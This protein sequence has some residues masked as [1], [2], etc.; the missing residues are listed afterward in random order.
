MRLLLLFVVILFPAFTSP[1]A[2]QDKP[3]VLVLTQSKGFV[4][5]VVKDKNGQ[6]SVVKQVFTQLAAANDFSVSFIDDV[7]E[8]TAERLKQTDVVAF[9]T[10]GDL[11][12][13][14]G[15]YDTFQQWIENGRAFLGIHCATDTLKDHDKYPAMIGA[16]FESHPWNA[17]DTVTLKVHDAEHPAA[18]PYAPSTTLK[19]EIYQFRNLQPDVIQVLIS[20]DMAKTSKKRPHHVPV[21]WI[22]H[23]GQGR[24]FYTSLGHRE[25]VWRSEAFG[26]HLV[27]AIRWLMADDPVTPNPALHESETKIAREAVEKS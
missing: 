26:R 20:L 14:N 8:L 24:V 25:D 10:T 2:A 15:Q 9:Y 18:A 3:Q 13:A 21:A 23:Q 5:D 11:P 19:E 6:P 16:I 1:L 4:H 17:G 7:A 22:K 12:F 27:G